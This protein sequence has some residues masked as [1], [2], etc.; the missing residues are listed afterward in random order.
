MEAANTS[1]HFL[2]IEAYNRGEQKRDQMDDRV[3][4]FV[5][6]KCILGAPMWDLSSNHPFIST[7]RLDD[8]YSMTVKI[9]SEGKIFSRSV[10]S[11]DQS[12]MI[13]VECYT[14]TLM[15]LSI[16]SPKGEL[17]YPGVQIPEQESTSHPL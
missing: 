14:P 16:T 10:A 5:N 12:A 7:Y 8:T 17:L 13:K 15:M 4:V 6:G 9:L 1:S 2:R 3:D 11:L